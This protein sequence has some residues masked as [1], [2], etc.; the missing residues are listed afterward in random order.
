MV[1]VE[2]LVL[3]A[4]QAFFTAEIA[5]AVLVQATRLLSVE[6]KFENTFNVKSNVKNNALT[7]DRLLFFFCLF[8]K[9]EWMKCI[10]LSNI[11]LAA[12]D[13]RWAKFQNHPAL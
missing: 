11:Y 3:F 12:R 13:Y 7:H 1:C 2:R 6:R 4:L 10:S 5:I 8:A 9:P